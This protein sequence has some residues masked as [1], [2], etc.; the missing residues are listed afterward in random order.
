MTDASY[1]E[2]SD[3]VADRAKRTAERYSYC[4]LNPDGLAISLITYGEI[5]EGILY[6]T[7]PDASERLFNHFLRNVSVLTITRR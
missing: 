5:Y 1:L 7:D 6:S 4:E 3:V 2:D